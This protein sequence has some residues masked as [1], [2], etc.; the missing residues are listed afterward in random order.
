[1]Q[2]Q[3]ATLDQQIASGD[4]KKLRRSVFVGYSRPSCIVYAIE[5]ETSGRSFMINAAQE[6]LAVR[7]SQG[8]LC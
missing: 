3:E 8:R 4:I 7:P 2:L 5:Q 1:V 6:E